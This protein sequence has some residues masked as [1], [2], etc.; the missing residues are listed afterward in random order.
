MLV[1]QKVLIIGG[2]SGFG[3]QLAQQVLMGLH[4]L[5]LEKSNAESVGPFLNDKIKMA[6]RGYPCYALSDQTK[7]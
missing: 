6:P 4:F 5:V 3:F 2:T 1:K 7:S